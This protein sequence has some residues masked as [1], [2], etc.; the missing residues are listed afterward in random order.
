M[1]EIILYM[2]ENFTSI[3]FYLREPFD[4]KKHVYIEK[5]TVVEKTF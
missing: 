1:R 5:E 2:T 3:I 4:L